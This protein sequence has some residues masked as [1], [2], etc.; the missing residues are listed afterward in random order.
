MCVLVFVCVLCIIKMSCNCMLY[1]YTQVVQNAYNGL[2]CCLLEY[3]A[4]LL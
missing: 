3:S 1:L 4:G 2:G